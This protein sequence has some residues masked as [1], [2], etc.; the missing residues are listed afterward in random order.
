MST[1]LPKCAGPLST[2]SGKLKGAPLD[3]PTSHPGAQEVPEHFSVFG[4]VRMSGRERERERF[5]RKLS[6]RQEQILKPRITKLGFIPLE[7]PVFTA[8]G[9]SQWCRLRE[10]L[11]P[12]LTFPGVLGFQ[13]DTYQCTLHTVDCYTNVSDYFK[14]QPCILV[15]LWGHWEREEHGIVNPQM[16]D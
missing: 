12:L 3:A 4:G 14:S 9:V 15:L 13:C 2:P 8:Q 10:R 16:H 5:T 11:L 6:Q 7:P 1:Q